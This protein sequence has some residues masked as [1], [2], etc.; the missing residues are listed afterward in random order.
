MF[1]HGSMCLRV[2]QSVI[3]QFVLISHTINRDNF[4]LLI[5]TG[6]HCQNDSPVDSCG[7]LPL[8]RDICQRHLV[9]TFH[10]STEVVVQ[11]NK[12]TQNT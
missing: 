9:Y 2:E 5:S 1:I 12:R 11:F 10:I 3:F 6:N 7:F 8:C 4:N